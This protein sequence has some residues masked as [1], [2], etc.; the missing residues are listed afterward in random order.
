MIASRR[1]V[2]ITASVLL[3]SSMLATVLLLR[4]VEQMRTAATL[5]DVLYITSPKMLKRLS[6]GYEGLMADIYWTRAVQYFGGRHAA[7]VDRYDLLAPL[8]ELTTALDPHLI[9]AYQ[10][11]G[12]FLAPAPP[13]GAGMPEKAIHLMEYGIRNNPDDWHLYYQL[14]FIYY[15]EKK[16]YASAAEAFQR[17]IRV[18]NTHPYLKVLAATM[19]QH[20]G[21]IQTARMLWLTTYQTTGDKLIRANAVAHLRALQVDEDVT[22]LQRAVELYQQRT[23]QLPPSISAMVAA[24][25]LSAIPVD[26]D[27]HTYKLLPDGRIELRNPQDFPFVEK[28][29]PPGYT[30]PPPKLNA[31]AEK[32]GQ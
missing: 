27:R 21:E 3:V 26:P 19:A 11:G 20:A 28:G 2:A 9:V 12:S 6:L 1:T 15:I 8:L 16:D 23:G 13:N 30:P 7:Y 31:T 24:G 25:F 4:R 18:P 5:E 14:G 29:L 32:S 17:G 10:F 22:L